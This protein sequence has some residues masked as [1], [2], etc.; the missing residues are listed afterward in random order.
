[1]STFR[2]GRVVD[3]HGQSPVGVDCRIGLVTQ[4]DWLFSRRFPDQGDVT[5][6]ATSL[7]RSTD[8]HGDR[9]AQ[10]RLTDYSQFRPQSG[11]IDSLI[12]FTPY[13]ASA[14]GMTY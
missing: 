13:V 3:C 10:D 7:L 14:D 9:D 12:I 11:A 8:R 5:A 2:S 6:V 1:M 4:D